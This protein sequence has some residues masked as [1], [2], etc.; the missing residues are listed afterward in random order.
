MNALRALV[1]KSLVTQTSVEGEARLGMLETIHEFASKRLVDTAEDQQVRQRHA[2]HYLALAERLAP[3]LVGR[4]QRRF[5]VGLLSDQDN[6]HA[7]LEWGIEHDDADLTSRLL[8]AL[9]WMWIPRGQFDEG[10]R[11]TEK[12]L[13]RFAGPAGW[14]ELAIIRE[15]K[16]WLHVL[17]GNY[18]Q[19][20]PF[21]EQSYRGFSDAA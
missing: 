10:H 15:V 21:F 20:R 17:G 4:D 2:A 3:G 11:W 8:N 1:N 18:E 13:Q 7:A 12:A 14:R 9:V 19:A 6:V 5:I 16:G